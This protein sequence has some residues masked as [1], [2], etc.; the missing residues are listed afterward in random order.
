M[1]VSITDIDGDLTAQFS[2]EDRQN[3]LALDVL[4][5]L[6]PINRV[7][8]VDAGFTVTAPP[9]FTNVEEAVNWARSYID[10]N[11]GEIT[12]KLY[13]DANGQPFDPDL[14]SYAWYAPHPLD[15]SIFVDTYASSGSS[16][17]LFVQ[18]LQGRDVNLNDLQRDIDLNTLP[19]NINLGEEGGEVGTRHLM[20]GAVTTEKVASSL[21]I[22]VTGDADTVDGEH[23]AD[24]VTQSRVEGTNPDADTVDGRE[25]DELMWMARLL[26]GDDINLNDA[27]YDMNL[28]DF[29]TDIQL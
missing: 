16:G 25:G 3:V 1:S 7:G 8:V 19:I 13:Y 18:I 26:R 21:G 23:A 5:S 29:R 10:E 6:E 2:A 22:D 15:S 17:G 20:D 27:P 24:I 4:E 14:A 12:L 28:N 9:Y 11:G